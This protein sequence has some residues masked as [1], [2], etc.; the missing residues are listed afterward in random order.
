MDII[1]LAAIATGLVLTAFQ[2][3]FHGFDPDFL[4]DDDGKEVIE[5]GRGENYG[6]KHAEHV[7]VA[8]EST[9][10]L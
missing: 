8:Q 10:A 4:F 9:E 6:Q 3:W 5:Y 7:R 1:S 2:F